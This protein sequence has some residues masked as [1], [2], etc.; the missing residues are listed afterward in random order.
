[1]VKSSYTSQYYDEG[2]REIANIFEDEAAAV[3]K[4]ADL[5]HK[6]HLVL[7]LVAAEAEKIA[8]RTYALIQELG[9][10]LDSVAEDVPSMSTYSGTVHPIHSA[11]YYD[12]ELMRLHTVDRVHDWS[13]RYTEHCGR[14]VERTNFQDALMYRTTEEVTSRYASQILKSPLENLSPE[15]DCR[16]SA[17]TLKEVQDRQGSI[18]LAIASSIADLPAQIAYLLTAGGAA[19]VGSLATALTA[20]GGTACVQA[21]AMYSGTRRQ[22]AYLRR[23]DNDV[24]TRL[25]AHYANDPECVN[26]YLYEAGF[27]GHAP[28]LL[29]MT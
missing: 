10:I 24:K 15:E 6:Q 21:G 3:R 17:L 14:L 25:W 18:R 28:K 23:M 8:E 5:R 11:D 1:M 27:S 20:V 9:D 4:A 12:Q 2:Q 7:P 29:G 22:A 26:E 16:R 13:R 19:A